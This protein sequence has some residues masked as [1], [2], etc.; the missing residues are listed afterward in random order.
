MSRFRTGLRLSCQE[1]PTVIK[2]KPTSLLLVFTL[3]V[4]STGCHSMRPV[5]PSGTTNAQ[6][7]FA[8]IEIGDLVAVEMQDGSRHRFEVRGIEGDA[9]VAD[10]GRRYAR[11]EMR[12]LEHEGVD[13]GK[14]VGLVTAIVAAYA[15]FWKIASDFNFF[16]S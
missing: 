16:G 2:L 13:A 7:T 11:G 14:T 9:L 3:G 15:I 6:R 5:L 4:A 8:R 12:K 10:S 1:I